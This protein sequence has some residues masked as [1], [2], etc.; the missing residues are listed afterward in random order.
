[1]RLII[2]W[3]ESQSGMFVNQLVDSHSHSF[4]VGVH[5]WENY[6]TRVDA[7]FPGLKPIQ[8]K[9]KVSDLLRREKPV[10]FL[11]VSHLNFPSTMA[12]IS[13]ESIQ[14][15]TR[16]LQY[17]AVDDVKS[18]FMSKLKRSAGWN[19]EIRNK[20]KKIVEKIYLCVVIQ[21]D[22]AVVWSPTHYGLY[23]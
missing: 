14:S 6:V 16:T 10:L 13:A 21:S 17:E 7:K 4:C 20:Q 23:V 15:G 5:V 9:Q 2:S 12:K 11:L 19:L 1:M 22:F 18:P 8:Y 3:K